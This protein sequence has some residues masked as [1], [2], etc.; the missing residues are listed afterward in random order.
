MAEQISKPSIKQAF[1][2][3]SLKARLVLSAL[4]LIFLIL[5]LLGLALSAAF[6]KHL[7]SSIKN[8][9]S[10]HNYAIL[11]VAEVEQQQLSM[12]LQ[13]AEPLFNTP[14]SGLYA[15]IS[16]L[17][18]ATEGSNDFEHNLHNDNRNL[19]LANKALW[20]SGSLLG[21]ELPEIMQPKQLAT[22]AFQQLHL[23]E[24]HYFVFSFAVSFSELDGEFPIVVHIVKDDDSFEHLV[25]EFQLQLAY[26]LGLLMLFLLA[27]LSVWL[28]WT[29]KPL[30]QLKQEISCIDNGQQEQLKGGY[31]QELQAVTT[32]LNLLL[33]TEK[34][35][36]IRYRNALSD[37]AHSLKTPLAVIQTQNDLSEESCQQLAKINQMIEHQLKR[38]QTA[39]Q[40]AWHLGV[41][42]KQVMDKLHGS[43]LKIYH[44]KALNIKLNI[45]E[46]AVFQ[47]DESDL[48]EILGNLL[49][50]ACKAA[51]QDIIC[52]VF[53]RQ[54]HALVIEIEDDGMGI[55]KEQQALI[56]ARGGRADTYQQGHG[57]GL[58]IV[59]D[60]VDSYQ[61][62]LTISSSAALRGA[63]FSLQFTVN[64]TAEK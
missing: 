40:S 8:E 16:P 4:S 36:R 15:V 29:L 28:L 55:S 52:S 25:T 64:K 38:A 17:A 44:D 56:L 37:L 26:G 20:T 7:L 43:L 48:L 11:A 47:G 23:S 5:P 6:E 57:I 22:P 54:P 1:A 9:L 53:Y 31:P 34:Q 10:A 50:N 46:E 27:L 13:L 60:L 14:Q 33:A 19:S 24:Q 21:I 39:G 42:V 2:S 41:N 35:Q 18:K 62:R 3:M 58:A 32:Q 51:K 45:T 63:K 61:G 49:D 59:N 12:P 30:R